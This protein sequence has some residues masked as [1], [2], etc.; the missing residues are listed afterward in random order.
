MARVDFNGQHGC[1]LTLWKADRWQRFKK[2]K[3]R[4][5]YAK[6]NRQSDDE[7]E[8]RQELDSIQ[9]PM[10]KAVC[11]SSGYIEGWRFY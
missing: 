4:K 5:R 1:R 6:R 3:F 8:G 2:A 9:K 10:F 11:P 7:Q